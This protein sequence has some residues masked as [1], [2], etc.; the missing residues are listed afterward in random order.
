MWIEELS[1]GRYKFIERYKDPYTE[2]LKKVSITLTSKSNVAK[3]QAQKD[4]NEKI[5]NILTEKRKSNHT[6]GELLDEWWDFHSQTVRSST[7]RNYTNIMKAYKR[8]DS[9]DLNAKIKN[10]DTQF[11]QK[12]INSLTF[13]HVQKSKYKSVLS[14]SFDY[15]VNMQYVQHNPLDKV[16]IPKPPK[17]L[18]TFTATKD[19]YLEKEEVN[20]LLQ[21]YYSTHQSRRT[22]MLIEFM[23]LTGV[24]IGEAISLQV[25]NY[26]RDSKTIDI[27][28]TLDYSK[29]YKNAVKELPKTDA[30][31]RT[32]GISNRVIEILD[33]VILENKLKYNNYSDGSYI[34][35]G[36]TGLP[37][38]VNTFNASLDYNN[39]K[40]GD[41]KINK[42]LHSHIFR[43][44]HISLLSE[45]NIPI[46]A[47]MQRVGHDDEKTTL[48]IYTHVTEKQKTDIVEKLN[49]LG[50]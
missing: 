10:T 25:K 12:F 9:L 42:N 32:I 35:I 24:R 11:F 37:I 45:L 19:L 4:L 7:I 14:M 34:F 13:S 15:A 41:K 40:L 17:T 21:P 22:G 16:I 46:K 30:S 26:H 27:H 47:I 31:Y 38:Q 49:N 28:G 44:S 36:K 8:S 5:D 3:K 33:T 1:K 6:L 29:G 43:H 23:Y 50:F 20:R 39:N 18:E 2:E 48:R